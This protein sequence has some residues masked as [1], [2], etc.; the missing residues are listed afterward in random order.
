MKGL[1]PDEA[2]YLLAGLVVNVA[3]F[4]AAAL[5]LHRLG[6]RVLGAGGRAAKR[7]AGGAASRTADLALLLFCFN[8]ASVFYS[9]AYS[10]A[11]F[12]AATWA[13]LLL[14]PDRHW[15]GVAALT[16][17]AAA[18]SNGILAA[19]FPLHKLA[20]AA[21]RQGHLPAREA[22]RAALSCCAILAPYAAMQGT[23]G[24]AARACSMPA[25]P[26]HRSGPAKET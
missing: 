18:R 1:L 24:W 3:A 21:R 8:P 2:A 14:L 19:W 26:T 22:V 17:A 6:L 4:C 11:L 25:R 7:G 9:A 13:G 5:C 20:A 15:A 10:E 12:A 23:L 16:A